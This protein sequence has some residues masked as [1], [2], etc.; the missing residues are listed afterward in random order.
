ME[1][2]LRAKLVESIKRTED[3]MSFRFMPKEKIDFLPGQFLQIVFNKDDGTNRELNKYLSF[4]SSPTKDYFEVT[5]RLS[6]SVFSE[7]LRSLNIS[8]EIA[9]KGPFGNCVFRGDY[10]KIVFLV[11]GIGITPVISITEYIV[12]KNLDTDIVLIYSNRTED[13]A[14]RKKLDGWQQLNNKIRILYTITDCKPQDKKCIAGHINMELLKRIV[15]DFPERMFFVFGPPS[16][17]EGIKN[18]CEE[19]FC[20]KENLR[21]ESF[22]GY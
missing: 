11:G 7:K 6:S 15:T 21:T 5:K 16:M 9:F 18:L 22:T 10:K 14:F 13:I 12:D 8:D 4:S 2:L 3:I 1:G 17:V 19:A 20:I